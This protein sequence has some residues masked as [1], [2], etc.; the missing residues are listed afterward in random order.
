MDY[1]N[2]LFCCRNFRA[3][4]PPGFDLSKFKT[5]F[6]SPSTSSSSSSSDDDDDDEFSGCKR[7]ENNEDDCGGGSTEDQLLNESI[8]DNAD[9]TVNSS[10]S[11]DNEK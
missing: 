8:D 7:K 2:F 10:E 5:N 3:P 11:G 6:R 9:E 1:Y 4:L